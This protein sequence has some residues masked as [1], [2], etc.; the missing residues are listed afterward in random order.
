MKK[1]ILMALSIVMV[2]AAGMLYTQDKE[3][4]DTAFLQRYDLD[5]MSRQDLVNYLD[6]SIPKPIELGAQISSKELRLLANDEEVTLDMSDDLF[7]LS[8]APYQYETHPCFDH[9]L[10]GCQAEMINTE[11]DVKVEDHKGNLVYEDT[12]RTG[13][14]GFA[15]IW[16]P[17]DIS[18]TISVSYNGKQ[19]V[20]PIGT[21]SMDGTCLTDLQLI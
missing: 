11:F 12:V 7:Y 6:S 17:R 1:K 4:A 8:I 19:A 13:L 9:V 16:L 3:K 2:I 15:G 5:Q 14:N 10:T 18:G 20:S 21:G